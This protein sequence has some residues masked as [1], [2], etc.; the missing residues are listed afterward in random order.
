MNFLNS[1]AAKWIFLVAAILGIIIAIQQLT[2][3]KDGDCGCGG[4]TKTAPINV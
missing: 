1:S 2:K 4:N 3:S